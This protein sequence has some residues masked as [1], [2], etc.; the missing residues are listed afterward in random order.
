[1]ADAYNLTVNQQDRNY[2]RQFSM[3]EIFIVAGAIAVAFLL[4]SLLLTMSKRYV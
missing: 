4:T 2:V 3:L 1:M